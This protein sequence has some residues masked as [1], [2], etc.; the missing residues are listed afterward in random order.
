[1]NTNFTDL[2]NGASDGTKDYTI[3]A[4]T[5]GGTATLNGNVVLGNASSDTLTITAVLSSSIALGTTWTYE[6]GTTAVGLKSLWLGSADSAA[7]GVRLIGGTMGASWTFTMPTAVP[8]NANSK[9]ISNTSGTSSWTPASVVPGVVTKTTT[10][11][12]VSADDLVLCDTSGGAWTLTLPAANAF[13]GKV[14]K[15]I[16]SETSANALTVS[17]AGSD[18]ITWPGGGTGVTSLKLATVGDSIEL[19]S[20]GSSVWYVSNYNVLVTAK[21][22][23]N[24]ADSI[25]NNTFET[26]GVDTAFTVNYDA[27]AMH[28]A[29]VFTIA[30]PGV[31]AIH[32]QIYFDASIVGTRQLYVNYNNGTR[33]KISDWDANATVV[34][35]SGRSPLFGDIHLKLAAGDTIR[36]DAVQDSGAGLSIGNEG[37]AAEYVMI[38][39]IS[40]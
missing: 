29:G 12:V 33:Y 13:T 16:K 1:L 26:I 24:G 19:I 32:G 6:I 39:R 35:S 30:V 17:R 40:P 7:F 9:L 20:N 14:V 22:A 11:S 3:S 8:A 21:C 37:A 25:A 31:Y 27:L 2:I 38:A 34:S 15:I 18:T 28:S 5:V 4:L 23:T 36:F 10:Y